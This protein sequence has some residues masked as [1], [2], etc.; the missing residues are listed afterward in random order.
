[1][2][3][4]AR[5][6]IVNIGLVLLLSATPSWGGP[7]NPTDSDENGNTTGETDALVNVVTGASGGFDNTAFGSQSLTNTTTGDN[8]TGID[9]LTLF[10]NTTGTGNTAAGRAALLGNETGSQNTAIDVEALEHSRIGNNNTAV[11][12]MAL[13]DNDSGSQNI[14]IGANALKQNIDGTWNTGVGGGALQFN[15][16]GFRNTV[17]GYQALQQSTGSTNI[18]VGY[19]AGINLL[20]GNNN[21]YIGH[22]G[23]ESESQTIRIGTAQTQT[24]IAGIAGV[25]VDNAEV[26]AVDATTGQLGVT[27]LSSARY[28]RDIAPMGARSDGI[29]R[30]RPVTFAYMDD[31][32]ATVR[33]GLMAEEVAE[34]YPQLVTHAPSGEIRTVRYHELIPMLL[35]ELQR[36][37]QDLAR[38]EAIVEQGRG[39][40]G[41]TCVVHIATS[42]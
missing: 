8:N 27:A 7:P 29:L 37:R 19:H 22:L 10:M 5:F 15:T 31:A 2:K 36:Q 42:P 25:N 17:M 30:L 40:D 18:A 6:L 1:M 24:F 26:V 39:A 28:R 11:G 9:V 32:R 3:R 14:A 23:A 21:V 34:V 13:H 12:F 38:L 16:S 35:N 33:Y 20:S 4:I 41:N